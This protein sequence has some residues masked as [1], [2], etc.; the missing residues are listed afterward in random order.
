VIRKWYI[1]AGRQD[2]ESTLQSWHE[3][4]NLKCTQRQLAWYDNDL[5]TGKLLSV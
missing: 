5:P 3:G 2:L 1:F 4:M